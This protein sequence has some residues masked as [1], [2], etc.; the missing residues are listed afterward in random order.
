[1]WLKARQLNVCF[2]PSQVGRNWLRWHVIFIIVIII[3]IFF[4]FEPVKIA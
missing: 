4:R 1:M 2:D 3:I